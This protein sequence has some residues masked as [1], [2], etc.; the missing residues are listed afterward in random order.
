MTLI[1]AGDIGG[2]KVTL[3]VFDLDVKRPRLRIAEGYAS[4]NFPD[5][6]SILDRFLSDHAM[7]PDCACFAVAGPVLAGKCHT[8][9]LPWVIEEKRLCNI[10]GLD[11]VW[12]INDLAA[13]A[14]A[15]PLLKSSELV[16]LNKGIRRKGTIGVIAAGTGLGEALL[17]WDGDS[18]HPISTEG[19]HAGFAPTN[20]LEA[21]LWRHVRKER[22][23]VSVERLL[24]GPGLVRIYEFLRANEQE[25]EAV[26]AEQTPNNEKPAVIAE[27]A[28]KGKN[29]LC[30][31]AL[32]LFV[33][34]YGAEAGNLALR[35]MT[36]G[37]IYLAG[38]IAPKIL[39]WIEK[40]R[41]MNAFSDKGRFSAL[42]SQIPVKVILNKETALL[43]AVEDFLNVR[44]KAGE[45]I[46]TSKRYCLKGKGISREDADRIAS[47]LLANDIVQTWR[48][49]SR[50]QWD[51]EVGVGI[52][53]PK[54]I[55]DHQPGTS[56][57]PIPSDDAL[58]KI[59]EERNLALNPNDIPHIRGYFLRPDVLEER[60]K[61]GLETPTDIELEYISQARSDH[62]NHNT[63][64]GMF[65]YRDLA[66]GE[67]IDVNDLF[68][69]CI[70]R[71]TLE[72]KKAKPWVISVLWDNAGIG[73]FDADH[74]YVIT[75]ETHNSPSNMEAY[76]GAITGIV[77]VYRDPMGTGKGARLICGMYGYCAGPRDYA[78]D[79]KPRLHPRRL[80]DG[81]IEGVRDGGNKSGIPTPYG[82]VFFDKGYLGKCLVFVTAM[83][84]MP[85]TIDGIPC[86]EKTTSPGDLIIMCG[87]R[88]GKDGIHGVTAA[89]ESF[90]AHTPAGHVQI[91]DPY[92]QKKMH[93]FL[94][95]ARD[96]GLIAF[97]TD[98]GG[99]G[100]SSSIGESARFSNG[101]VVELEK[102]PLKYEGLDQ[103][104][105]WISESQERMTI[106]INP[107]DQARFFE[108]SKK[109][110]VESTVIGHYTDSGKL[111]IVYN[112]KTCAYVDMD[113]MEADFPQWVFDAE[114]QSPAARGLAEPV[115]SDPKAASH[116]LCDLLARPNICSKEWIVRQ[117]DHEVQGTS[118]IKPLVGKDRDVNSDAAVIR[119]A[120]DSARGL[121][122]AQAL[123]PAYSKIDTY[124]MAACA[125]DEAVR[126]VISVGGDPEHIGGV[127]N[128]CW[129]NIQYDPIKNPDGKYK[130]AQLVRANWAL[131]DV[132]LAYQIPLLSGKDS[133]YVDGYL[134]GKYGETHKV[135]ALCTLQFSAVSLVPDISK[136]VTME[137][138]FAQDLVYV[139]G[140]TKDELGASEYYEHFGKI[141]L[142][143]PGVTPET[144]IDSYR[145]VNKAIENEL[146]ASV[147][148]VYRGGLGV[149]LAMVAMGGGLGMSIDLAGVPA[150]GLVRN[151]TILYS[152]SAGRFIVTID[153]RRRE[154]FESLV[155]DLPHACIGTV[156]DKPE[157]AVNGL[158]QA[159]LIRIPLSD[160]KSAWK[161]PFGGLV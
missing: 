105:I 102:V 20:L 37:G 120:L 119:P 34:I 126:R 1:L 22:G 147:H 95:E 139:L 56:L 61:V 52:T 141:G 10:L 91:G 86:E 31:K 74:Y 55:I 107:K 96:E 122:A 100:L 161:L 49:F 103:W 152:E 24:S 28:M 63:F 117:Y 66:T 30:E 121:A 145:A 17:F 90:S 106:A 99:G 57:I 93:D 153:P 83:G 45:A 150:E 40:G 81:V 116:V 5:F 134:K 92:T 27:L 21:E 16:T 23:H 69:T 137:A 19:G 51:P 159:P 133:M 155:S 50:D 135:S 36:T 73:R 8:T 15:V 104:E 79:L 32:D 123:C 97:I 44:F 132:C 38:G 6:E 112:E 11:K 54:V 82:Q 62:C 110:A 35:G 115:L 158:D 98:N 42:L 87:G 29:T 67:S 114:W 65:H 64:Q 41:F 157:L 18:Y 124:N 130:A 78:G 48:I 118:V 131:R 75:G 88:V 33:S 59:S 13:T 143:V 89:S 68:D 108:L 76:G 9:N 151:D 25:P 113:F 43:G 84:L 3:G 149:H 94:S 160:L 47:E 60:R 101:C 80:L 70:R 12:L 146:V 26:E 72:I 2:T 128:F 127:D 148:G 71:P 125:V 4:R 144:F 85:A 7:R 109:H 77:G 58:A 39:K 142:N 46:Y 138:K 14:L 154:A 156:T 111:H 136:C 53:V 140:M 129:P